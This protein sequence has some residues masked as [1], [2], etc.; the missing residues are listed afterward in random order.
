[1][2]GLRL[3]L[4]RGILA[5]TVLFIGTIVTILFLSIGMAETIHVDDS[6]GADYETIQEA[7]DNST[8]GD[9]IVVMEGEYYENVDVSKSLNIIGEGPGISI[10]DGGFEGPVITVKEDNT[11]LSGLTI[12]NCGGYYKEAGIILGSS[13]NHIENINFTNN[14]VA[15]IQAL[16]ANNFIVNCTI[17][18]SY[19][20]INSFA[21][22]ISISSTTITDS[23]YTGIRI[24]EGNNSV[25]QNCSIMDSNSGI[26]LGPDAWDCVLTENSFTGCGIDPMTREVPISWESHTI[27]SSNTVNGRSVIFHSNDSGKTLSSPAGQII[28]INCT[29]MTIQDQ[30]P[31]NATVGIRLAYCSDIRIVDSRIIDTEDIGIHLYISD[32]ITIEN[33]TFS[34][35]YQGINIYCSADVTIYSCTF[36]NN[37]HGIEIVRLPVGSASRRI[38]MADN[39]FSENLYGVYCSTSDDIEVVN[40]IFSSNMVASVQ[41]VSSTDV[42]IDN[43]SISSSPS[44]IYLANSI[45]I[46]IINN[47]I[48][49]AVKGILLYGWD[50]V[51]IIDN[52]I[53]NNDYGIFATSFFTNVTIRGNRI[54]GNLE[55]GI[56]VHGD[57]EYDARHNWWGSGHG[58]YHEDLNPN[59]RGDTLTP[60]VLFDPWTGKHTAKKWVDDDASDDGD[61]TSDDPY[62]SIQKAIDEILEGGIIHVADGTYDEGI[63]VN[64]QV[65]ILGNGSGSTIIDGGGV[66]DPITI[67][68]NGVNI[69]D[70]KCTN[71]PEGAENAGLI[72]GSNDNNITRID[73]SENGGHG[74]LLSSAS[75]NTIM[76]AEA[77][78][79]DGDGIHLSNSYANDIIWTNVFRNQV[80]GIDIHS[81]NNNIISLSEVKWNHRNGVL[82]QDSDNVEVVDDQIIGNLN[83]VVVEGSSN[84]TIVRFNFFEENWNSALDTSGKTGNAL[85]VRDNWWGDVTGPY[86]PESNALGRG[87][88]VTG[89]VLFD[90]WFQ[91]SWDSVHYVQANIPEGGDR[92]RLHPFPYIQDAVNV[93]K[94]GDVVRI[95]P[96]VYDL[97][98]GIMV[99]TSISIIGSGL[100][101]T[102]LDGHHRIDHQYTIFLDKDGSRIS[103]LTLQHSSGHHEC[104]AIGLYSSNHTITDNYLYCNNVGIYFGH[105]HNNTISNNK[106]E[107]NAWN[108]RHDGIPTNNNLFIGNVITRKMNF[109]TYLS[110]SHN[111]FSDNLIYNY[112]GVS[113][114]GD[115]VTINNNV[116]ESSVY[117]G[118]WEGTTYK[119][120]MFSGVDSGIFDNIFLNNDV[121]LLIKNNSQRNRINSN[122]FIGNTIGIRAY[123]D[124]RDNL[125]N[126]NTFQNNSDYGIFRM[127]SNGEVL[128]ARFNWW[129]VPSGP[130]HPNNNTNG[131]GD[132][133]SDHVDFSPWVATD[134]PIARILD[135]SPYPS[136]VGEMITLRGDGISIGRIIGFKWRSS[137]DGPISEEPDG[138]LFLD[139][140]SRGVHEIFLKVQG[141]I[142]QWSDEVSVT[143]I[144]YI[145]PI[146][147][148]QSEHPISEPMILGENVTFQ[149]SLLTDSN[150]TT[151]IWWSNL[152]GEIANGTSHS[153]TI[154][155]LSHG[156]HTIWVQGMDVD[157]FWSEPD[158]LE[159]TLTDIPQASNEVGYPSPN[160]ALVGEPIIFKW[161]AEGLDEIIR[162]VWRSDVQGILYSGPDKEFQIFNLSVGTHSLTLRCVNDHG[163]WS[164][165][166]LTTITIHE[167]PTS[168]I[169]SINPVRSY[170]GDKIEFQGTGWDDGSIVSFQ[171]ISS[172][173]GIFYGGTQSSFETSGLSPGDHH[174][175]LRVRDNYGI[176]SGEAAIEIEVY[177]I[178]KAM[179]DSILS[180]TPLEHELV[181]FNANLNSNNQLYSWTSSI[182]G[183]FSN[184]SE[185]RTSH[186][187]LSNGTHVIS[188]K[189]MDQNGLWSKEAFT[190]IHVN[191]KPTCGII[192]IDPNTQ[193]ES[194]PISFTGIAQDDGT[195]LKYAWVS[196]LGG[197]LYVGGDDSFVSEGLSVGD[198]TITL[199]VMDDGGIWSEPRSDYLTVINR[200]PPNIIPFVNIIAPRN[201][202]EF[203]GSIRGTA[204]DID[205]N[206]VHVEFSFNDVDWILASGTD[207]WELWMNIEDVEAGAYFLSVRAFDGEDHS[208]VHSVQVYVQHSENNMVNDPDSHDIED[209]LGSKDASE[210]D[211][212]GS[213]IFALAVS[214]AAVIVFL[215]IPWHDWLNKK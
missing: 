156:D 214:I 58:P 39:L 169:L 138:N 167:R 143:H 199:R 125:I 205:G 188:L 49:G 159:L 181:H 70:L 50:L 133:V 154:S 10:I 196:S 136:Q 149:T 139:N 173:D 166:A 6:G 82:I 142:R 182:D 13:F 113:L 202:E 78:D 207:D 56:Q 43:N 80:D 161:E 11:N 14:Q 46:T 100:E 32:N 84:N 158:Y 103:G 187:G 98:F 97:E 66:K 60:T 146:I 193:M 45:N 213:V 141:D 127:G 121:G 164:D 132:A 192:S 21:N 140:L 73:C 165:V 7:I 120:L 71:G 16:R 67:T 62:N 147:M 22:S 93:T 87:G 191:G 77:N 131:T 117:T 92:S 195:I 109:G 15:A 172:I 123:S 90:P 107:Y 101:R 200:D 99:E 115:N 105:S 180:E 81:S 137:I 152:D 85:D 17:W 61:G 210:D 108:L 160:P 54:H 35:G 53:S 41:F 33:V 162:Y 194:K 204:G 178:P 119:G 48:S 211:G 163:I 23:F 215:Y 34:R 5:G 186:A 65:I 28:L 145:Q 177:P 2:N 122:K 75:E 190:S 1:M 175:S 37:F 3:H 25:I 12:R 106:F 174:I 168:S 59:G 198:H 51:T 155:S 150:I 95:L 42:L 116:F 63:L 124:I 40:S 94:D 209:G 102:V 69:S 68:A 112:S 86:E 110:G 184:S 208:M 114:G 55:Y 128:D 44:G 203:N 135:I 130:Y 74:I 118:D 104:G 96:G 72:I 52:D 79:N 206:V 171:W 153:I 27:D 183:E 212:K 24:S 30:E 9:T 91:V 18:K 129:C 47:N 89:D 76:W 197:T 20:G 19:V 126:S 148:I 134:I 201:G 189:V 111:T 8:A 151:Y 29:E 88:N 64:K 57:K 170:K 179:I 4:K 144:V 31:N 26:Q 185:Y 36:A 176:W 83:G 157:G 38:R